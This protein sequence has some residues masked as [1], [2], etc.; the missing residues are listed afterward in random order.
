MKKWLA[1]LWRRL[2]RDHSAISQSPESRTQSVTSDLPP[3]RWLS[4]SDNPFGVEVLDCSVYA[5]SM[6]STTK[7]IN[8][9]KKYNDLRAS[10][11]QEFRG[12]SP[13]ECRK[14]ACELNYGVNQP[15]SNGPLFKSQAMEDKWDIYF[16]DSYLYFT[17]SWSGD[18]FFRAAIQFA[19]GKVVVTEIEAA[20]PHDGDDGDDELIKR[21]VDF[22]IKSH[23]FGLAA[24]HPLPKT[25]G[26]APP[27]YLATY[28]FSW[29]GRWGRYGTFED[30]LVTRIANHW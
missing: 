23:L 16:F 3:L 25:H 7:D 8:L 13:P 21:Q 24:L 5:T 12:M 10:S 27:Y 29:F 19:D 4:A 30:T 28:S 18:L 14:I 1:R 2:R 26:T 11:G 9:A 6:L 15:L 22:L 20:A 17:R